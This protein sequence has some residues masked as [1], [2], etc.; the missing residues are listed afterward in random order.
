M[1]RLVYRLFFQILV[2]AGSSA[3][4]ILCSEN[5]NGEVVSLEIKD[6]TPFADKYQ[7]GR[8]GSYEK[9]TGRVYFAVDPDDPENRSIVDLARAPRDATGKVAFWSDF[10]LLSP[11]DPTR[12]NRRLIYA[13]NNRGNKLLLEYFNDADGGNNPASLADAGNGFL[14]RRG[15]SILWSGWNGDVLPG[16]NRLTA[17]FPIAREDDKPIEGKVYVQLFTDRPVTT[18]PLVWGNSDSYP[19]TNLDHSSL[20]LTMRPAPGKE[21][22]EIAPRLLGVCPLG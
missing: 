21:P 11:I 19:T 18:L 12:G 6:R 9:I 16:D 3:A 1:K 22:I 7:F 10:C 5:V 13:V 8:T 2:F 17:G 20:R 15:Y 14:M 4:L